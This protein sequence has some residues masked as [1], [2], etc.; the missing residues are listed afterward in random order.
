MKTRKG[1]ETKRK[2]EK[3]NTKERKKNGVG[4]CKKKMKQKIKKTKK[5]KV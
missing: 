2:T 4:C 3:G 1:K 5:D